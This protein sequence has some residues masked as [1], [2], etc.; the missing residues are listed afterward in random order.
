[1]A[2][3]VLVAA[4]VYQYDINP[5]DATSNKFHFV[6]VDE[7]FSK[8]ADK[9]ARYAL[10]LFKQFGLQLLMV[11]PLDAKARICEPYVGV[12]AHVV[13]DAKTNESEILSYTSE[14]LKEELAS[15]K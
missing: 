12:H 8:T 15:K 10:D 13:K 1:M 14:V 11:A 7:M 6:M 5:D 2:F 9:Y 3:L 4:I